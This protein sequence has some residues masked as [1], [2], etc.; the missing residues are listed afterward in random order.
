MTLTW[1]AHRFNR[2]RSPHF[3]ALGRLHGRHLKRLSDLTHD[4]R[5]FFIEGVGTHLLLEVFE[6]V[7]G[8]SK[9]ILDTLLGLITCLLFQFIDLGI[10][11][12]KL[13]LQL[14]G[15]PLQVTKL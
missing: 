15:L 3:P 4:D 8:A 13:I 2:L 11:L 7:V 14:F 12:T 6:D 1:R 9:L 10:F 5:V